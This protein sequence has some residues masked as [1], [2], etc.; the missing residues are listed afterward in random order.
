M[1]RLV[2]SHLYDQI[3]YLSF[4]IFAF[5]KVLEDLRAEHEL[6]FRYEACCLTQERAASTEDPGGA[7]Y[8]GILQGSLVRWVDRLC[9]AELQR[10]LASQ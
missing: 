10:I 4:I 3:L 9:Q 7:V 1:P 2:L 6:V 5:W 8:L